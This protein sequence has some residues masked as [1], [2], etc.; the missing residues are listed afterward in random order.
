MNAE[1]WR[2]K[3]EGN[4]HRDADTTRILTRARWL[5]LRFCEQVDPNAAA[6]KIAAALESRQ[7]SREQP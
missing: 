6:R 7:R 1:W 3:I 4:R 2:S 5:V